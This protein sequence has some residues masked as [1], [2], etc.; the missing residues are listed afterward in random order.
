[1]ASSIELIA[2][3]AP[4]RAQI[5]GADALTK[6]GEAAKLSRPSARLA[7]DSSAATGG[8]CCPIQSCDSAWDVFFMLCTHVRG[9][10]NDVYPYQK[11]F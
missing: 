5:H 10:F 8:Q 3:L 6:C 1:M 7:E 4:R 11:C 9:G 2:L